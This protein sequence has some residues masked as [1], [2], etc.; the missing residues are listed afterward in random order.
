M[1]YSKWQL[2]GDKGKKLEIRQSVYRERRKESGH[3][4]IYPN[5]SPHSLQ[6][7]FC[8]EQVPGSSWVPCKHLPPCRQ[9]GT[10][11]YNIKPLKMGIFQRQ[12]V[13][14]CTTMWMY[15]MPQNC[16]LKNYKYVKC[17]VYFTTM[18]SWKTRS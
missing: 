13:A 17:Y 16:T 8:F 18:K 1:G 4:T 11:M 2:R 5:Y 6:S 10:V 7:F 9:C 3:N 14:T 12:I 15:V